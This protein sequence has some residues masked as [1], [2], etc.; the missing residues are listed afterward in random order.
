MIQARVVSASFLEAY[1]HFLELVRFLW[2]LD[3]DCCFF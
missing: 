2:V 3:I 1:I